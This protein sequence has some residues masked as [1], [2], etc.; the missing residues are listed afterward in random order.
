MTLI[1][2]VCP[3]SGAGDSSFQNCDLQ[4]IP[5][6]EDDRECSLH[7]FLRMLQNL[8]RVRVDRRRGEGG[9][10]AWAGAWA[11]LGRGWAWAG[12]GGG[13]RAEQGGR[14]WGRGAAGGNFG[15]GGRQGGCLQGEMLFSHWSV[16]SSPRQCWNS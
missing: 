6:N 3:T 9:G 1:V 5:E 8:S 11:G 4:P 13:G 10:R 7:P 15:S 2:P 12:G 16:R 14:G